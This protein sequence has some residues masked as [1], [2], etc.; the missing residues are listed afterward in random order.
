[1]NVSEND[2]RQETPPP[3]P[4]AAEPSY[5][6]EQY[7]PRRARRWHRERGPDYDP[8]RKSV[9][10]ACILS[11]LPGLGQ[12]YLGY[13]KLGF[14]HVLVVGTTISM[15]ANGLI[16][17]LAPLFGIF[18][19]FFWLYNI[20]DAGRRAAFYNLAL[21]GLDGVE[22]PEEM[23]LPKLGGSLFGGVVLMAVGFMLLS[24]TAFDYSL[25]WLEDWWPVAPILL[26]AYLFAR[27]MMDRVG[28]D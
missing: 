3:E 20:V 18:L 9:P 17:G 12:I 6:A 23:K 14:I 21:A 4:P 16:T 13:Y 19:A 5:A 8:R 28:K 15:L 27:G 24:N 1:M 7:P 25:D 22:M 26:G 11:A 10:L 2:V